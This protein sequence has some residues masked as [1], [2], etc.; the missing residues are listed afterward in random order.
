MTRRRSTNR[1]SQ[2][3]LQAMIK[4]IEQNNILIQQ[5]ERKDQIILAALQQNNELL[6]QLY[7][8]EEGQPKKS[9]YLDG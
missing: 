3:L 5:S 4:L 9:Q 1:Q 2:E 6:A 8:D 7:D